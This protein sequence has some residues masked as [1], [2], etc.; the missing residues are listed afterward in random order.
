MTDLVP[1]AGAGPGWRGGRSSRARP[2]PP[3][4]SSYSTACNER[5]S[6]HP[7]SA[8]F[9]LTY[10]ST[11]TIFVRRRALCTQFQCNCTGRS[12]SAYLTTVT[13]RPHSHF[14][15]P[16]LLAWRQA[17]QHQAGRAGGAGAR[18]G[19]WT[20]VGWAGGA[21]GAG[22][23]G[24][25]SGAG[26]EVAGAGLPLLLLLPL[27]LPPGPVLGPPAGH[28]AQEL[29]VNL[30]HHPFTLKLNIILSRKMIQT[31]A[32]SGKLISNSPFSRREE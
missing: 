6:C 4:A 31:L 19:T 14:R 11:S 2:S 22:S 32:L 7:H 29:S 9:V 24:R 8:A 18:T 23:T 25:G 3:A 13:P 17:A 28:L 30:Q 26:L 27:R 16:L 20:R 15:S 10:S 21:A 1:R 12:N 5:S